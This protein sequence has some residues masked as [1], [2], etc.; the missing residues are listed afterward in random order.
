MIIAKVMAFFNKIIEE[1]RL[2]IWLIQDSSNL[3][4]DKIQTYPQSKSEVDNYSG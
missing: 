2:I 4:K 1:I 3:S